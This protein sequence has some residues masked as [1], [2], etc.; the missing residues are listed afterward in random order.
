MVGDEDGS[1]AWD[2]AVFAPGTKGRWRV[3]MRVYVEQRD[4]VW[5]DVSQRLPAADL[6]GFGLRPGVLRAVWQ[7]SSRCR[8][9]VMQ[10]SE[11]LM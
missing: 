1:L 2:L 8:V 4:S 10:R 11:K 5:G 3:H 9:T 7:D 6:A